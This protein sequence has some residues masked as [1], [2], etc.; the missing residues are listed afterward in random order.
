MRNILICFL[1]GIYAPNL[2]SQGGYPSA[3][4]LKESIRDVTVDEEVIEQSFT[5]KQPCIYTIT[6]NNITDDDSYAYEFNAADLNEY[7]ITFETGK[8]E[9]YIEVETKGAKDLIRVYENEKVDGY[10]K[11][12]KFYARDV[13]H[14]R[15]L[16]EKFKALVRNCTGTQKDIGFVLGENAGLAGAL[17]Y[18]T[19]NIIKVSVNES[20][21][22]QTFSYNNSYTPLMK[23]HLVDETKGLTSIYELNAADL[24]HT[25]VQFDTRQEFVIV[26]AETRGERDLIRVF[27]N[28]ELDGYENE[29]L[30][31][32]DNIEEARKLVE[33]FKYYIVEAAKV[34]SSELQSLENQADIRGVNDFIARHVNDVAFNDKSYK[35]SFT[36]LAE[37]PYMAELKV[38]NVND[39]EVQVYN[40]NLADI[41]QN[42]VSFDTKGEKVIIEIRT[43]GDRDLLMV[44]EN[45]EIDDYDSKIEIL[46]NGIEEA[47]YVIEGVKKAVSLSKDIQEKSFI[48]GVAAPD[49]NQTVDFLTSTIKDVVIGGDAYKQKYRANDGNNCLAEIEIIDV[50]EGETIVYKFNFIDINVHKIAFDTKGEEVFVHIETVGGNDLI[51]LIEDGI[52]DDFKDELEIRANGIE[53]ARKIEMALKHLTNL[54][55]QE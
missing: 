51:E 9:V 1:L 14:A 10:D 47:R 22:N 32:A 54:C 15:E 52:T 29:I 55:T 23:L 13:E 4:F 27:E 35:Q 40:F 43:S 5:E 20:S 25:S 12:F 49:K 39:A 42:A 30:F 44:H 28:G 6:V 17:D 33:V 8:K 36:H 26:T 45:G 31:Y 2:L 48:T 16:V 3:D 38:E 19:T 11:D 24:S 37:Q 34:K 7:K 21:F 46:A 18:L 53:E 41:N 50:S